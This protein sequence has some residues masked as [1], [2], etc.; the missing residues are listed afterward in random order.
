[1]GLSSKGLDHA[2]R[3]LG[4]RRSRRTPVVVNCNGF[5]LEEYLRLIDALQPLAEGLEISLSC[6]NESEAGGDFLDPARAEK[7]FVEMARRK[8]R[9][10]FIKIPGY[11][12]EAERQTRLDLIDR[13]LYYG[14]DGVTVTVSPRIE[15]PRLA[16]GH[17]A[18]SGAPLLQEML[19]VVGDV[20]RATQ[21]RCHIKARGGIFAPEDAFAAIAAGGSTVEVYSSFIYEGWSVARTINRGLLGLLDR[22]HIADVAALRGIDVR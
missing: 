6:S 8:N 13:A 19:R 4:R 20:Y 15:E 17:G 1:M 12:S 2:A 18:L 10:L 16:I 9:P 21:G 14:V 3:C 22:H 5:T 11:A 7:L